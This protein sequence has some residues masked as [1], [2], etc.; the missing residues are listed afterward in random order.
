MTSLMTSSP[1]A[2]A[3]LV[4]GELGYDGANRGHQ[5]D[6]HDAG[7][8]L[9]S[10]TTANDDGRRPATSS[11]GG[12]VLVVVDSDDY[13]PATSGGNRGV[14]GV[15]LTAANPLKVTAAEGDDG[16]CSRASPEIK[17]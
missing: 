13:F 8:S 14:Y 16:R 3:P 1:A 15:L 4:A 6:E 17:T 12:E 5:R 9:R 7:N 10:S 11:E 2:W